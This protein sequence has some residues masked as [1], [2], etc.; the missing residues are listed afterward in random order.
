MSNHTQVASK[1]QPRNIINDNGTLRVDSRI[2]AGRFGIQHHNL[3][4]QISKYSNEFKIL[5]MLPFQTEEIKG[6]RQPEKYALLNEDQTIFIL[7]L[8]CNTP[9]VVQL[10]LDLTIDLL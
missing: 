2:I 3:M 7:T 8:S 6:C 4:E 9:Q 5:G 10:K 1:T